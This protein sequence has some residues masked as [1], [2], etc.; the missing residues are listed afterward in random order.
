MLILTR[1][2]GEEI[3]IAKGRIKICLLSEK[4]GVIAVGIKAPKLID[5]E[6]KEVFIRN[7]VERHKAVQGQTTC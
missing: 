2:I 3:Y 1:R 7:Q 5:I 6:R 4:D